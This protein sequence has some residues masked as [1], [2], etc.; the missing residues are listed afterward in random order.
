MNS[1]ISFCGSSD[2]GPWDAVQHDFT[3]CFENVV[4]LSILPFV[5]IL[6]ASF[7]ILRMKSR[8]AYGEYQPL[9][10]NNPLLHDH[11]G[12]LAYFQ[13]LS[14]Q[15]VP[16]NHLPGILRLSSSCI[17]VITS[18]LHLAFTLVYHLP[19]YHQLSASLIL[20]QS[21]LSLLALLRERRA[22][23]RVS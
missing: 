6:F 21:L 7:L 3:S 2:W 19:M 12:S 18:A 13:R 14:K 11:C 16:A 20:A 1:N 22:L 8:G 5:F 9:V 23:V 15:V 17:F 10:G 4:L